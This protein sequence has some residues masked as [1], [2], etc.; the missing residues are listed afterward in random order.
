MI[1]CLLCQFNLLKK[2]SPTWMFNLCVLLLSVA[3]NGEILQT[4]IHYG[5]YFCIL[6]YITVA[7]Q[8]SLFRYVLCQRKNYV[9]FERLPLTQFSQHLS[10]HHKLHSLDQIHIL[11]SST[12]LC[13]WKMVYIKAN[14]LKQHWKCGVYSVAPLLRGHR[15]QVA[16]IDCDSKSSQSISCTPFAVGL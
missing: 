4:V 15:L 1:V 5:R 11:S 6:W 9:K 14:T 3:K 16:T 12:H 8:A 13:K 7:I 2:Y 10:P